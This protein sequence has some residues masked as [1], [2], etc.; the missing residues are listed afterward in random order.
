MHS[1]FQNYYYYKGC[2]SSICEYDAEAKVIY[3]GYT[4]A[5]NEYVTEE[6][7][8]HLNNKLPDQIKLKA[9][10][11]SKSLVPEPDH[12]GLTDTSQLNNQELETNA[13]LN[14]SWIAPGVILS[15]FIIVNLGAYLIVSRKKYSNKEDELNVTTDEDDEEKSASAGSGLIVYHYDEL[16][17]EG[18][19]SNGNGNDNDNDNDNDMEQNNK[20][21]NIKNIPSM[22]P[23]NLDNRIDCPDAD[24][25]NDMEMMKFNDENMNP[26]HIQ[27][28]SQRGSSQ[29]SLQLQ[30]EKNKNHDDDDNNNSTQ[31]DLFHL[32]EDE[33]SNLKDIESNRFSQGWGIFC[34]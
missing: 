22:F 26:L 9:V 20:R 28:R 29:R 31:K 24:I 18:G 23:I 13:K 27:P 2:I 21:N 8:N 11:P 14:A 15:A 33:Q 7:T 19:M 16:D 12:G 17:Q 34:N 4:G 1:S 32:E 25:N 10:S 6:I 3:T 5:D 30:N